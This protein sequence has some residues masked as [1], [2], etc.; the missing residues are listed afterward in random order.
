M[1]ALVQK[2]ETAKPEA[3]SPDPAGDKKQP[4]PAPPLTGAFP[5][6]VPAVP[7]RAAAANAAATTNPAGTNSGRTGTGGRGVANS[8]A[9]HNRQFVGGEL[10]ARPDIAIFVN[11]LV[12]A[13]GETKV[14]LKAPTPDRCVASSARIYAL[15]AASLW[16]PD[17]RLRRGG[18]QVQACVHEC[19]CVR[20]AAAENLPVPGTRQRRECLFTCHCGE[21]ESLFPIPLIESYRNVLRLYYGKTLHDR[22][23]A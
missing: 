2:T 10:N 22:E 12:L 5:S 1:L 16:S 9:A 19:R 4:E 18:E 14:T 23:G 15:V 20:C 6:P 8:I 17:R 11:H 21:P 13:L 3:T 7:G